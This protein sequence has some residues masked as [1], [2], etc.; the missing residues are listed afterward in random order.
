[1]FP[2]KKYPVSITIFEK[3]GS[4]KPIVFHDKGARIMKKTGEIYYQLKKRK[5]K[6][7][8]ISYDHIFMDKQGKK[9]EQRVYLYSNT[10]YT[11]IPIKLNESFAHALETED[12]TVEEVEKNLIPDLIQKGDTHH[13]FDISLKADD[14]WIYWASQ[15]LKQNVYRTQY[16]STLEKILPIAMVA[17][18]GIVVGIM[19]Y[20]TIGQMQVI[21]TAFSSA[22]TSMVEV[23]KQLVAVANAMKGTSTPIPPPF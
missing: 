20:M 14:K 10:P 18:T 12:I 13:S 19:L 6:T 3:R 16:K 23:A 5:I 11:Y 4:G 1:M 7:P 2:F 22:T 17:T 21:S 9:M 15:Q 8:P